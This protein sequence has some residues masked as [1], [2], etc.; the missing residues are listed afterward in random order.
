MKLE[1]KVAIVTGAGQGIG[2]AIALCFAQEGA[3]IAIP[4]INLDGAEAV[5]R[6]VEA[7]GRKA[8]AKKADVAVSTQVK[9]FVKEAVSRFD[10][11][12]ILVNNAGTGIIK[13]FFE[14]SDE[15]WD[16]V[17]KTNLYGCFYCSRAVAKHMIARREGKIVNIA[18]ISGLTGSAR[19]GA[20]GASK[21]G[22]ITFTKIMAVELAKHGINVNALTPGPVTTPLLIS[23]LDE[24][25]LK[26]YCRD[27]PFKRLGETEEIADAA[28]F[29]CS[30]DSKYI[31]GHILA[32]DGGFLAAGVLEED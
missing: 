13:S 8:F 14:L 3:H 26:D 5:A 16:T 2:R 19:R 15:E 7:L 9:A 23:R 30:S 18:S 25:Q 10:K 11:I 29:L 6:E 22:I 17:L 27:I 31:T 21:G 4:D 1:N 32:V 24:S 12:D 28:L 20:Y